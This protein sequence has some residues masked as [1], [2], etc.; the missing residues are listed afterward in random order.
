MSFKTDRV[1]WES[2]A[3]KA[4]ETIG[5]K[6]WHWFA[7]HFS[8]LPNHPF[9]V[10][11]IDACV[12]CEKALPGL[13]FEFIDDLASISGMERHEPHYDQLLQKLSELLVLRRLFSLDWPSGTTFE[14]EPAVRTNGKRPELRVGTPNANYLFEVKAPSLLEHQRL[15]SQNEMQ[16]P[17]RAIPRE[18]LDKLI[19]N[20]T[21][22]MA[23]DLP[24]KDFL[25]DADKKFA[26]FKTLKP[27]ASVL[28]IVWDDFIY[29]PITSLT[30]EDCGLL[31]PNSFYKDGTG[32]AV[33][34]SNIDAV[35][36][37]RHLTYFKLA[38]A[39]AVLEERAHAL[40]FGGDCDLP[41]VFVPITRPTPVPNYVLEGLRAV[42][43]DSP[44]L[45]GA[46][47]YH[48]H[49]LVLWFP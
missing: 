9:A 43:I 2:L 46:A 44:S 18:K 8:N 28:V 15:R 27:E 13:G 4:F 20:R 32:S 40:D 38:A 39:D 24:V 37:V 33:Q 17:G 49:E 12:D 48:A 5:P 30:H 21:L 10:S 22:T 7:F 36:I 19:G 31:T 23:R 29:E 3:R 11:V 1:Q 6:G 25:I 42:P 14:H 41:N 16:A 34:F 35:V 47:E 26:Q 45:K